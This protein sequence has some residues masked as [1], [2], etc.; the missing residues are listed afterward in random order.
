M[1]FHNEHTSREASLAL[2][3]PFRGASIFKPRAKLQH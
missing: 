3:A 2:D 1:V